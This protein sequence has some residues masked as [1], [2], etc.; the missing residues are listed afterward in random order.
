MEANSVARNADPRL[1]ALR[2][3]LDEVLDDVLR[4]PGFGDVRIDIRWLKRGQKEVVISSAKQ[5]RFVIPV[6]PADAGE[7][8]P[9]AARSGKEE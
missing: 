4:H 5:H 2:S 8:T 1:V 7:P 9:P 3:K 6:D